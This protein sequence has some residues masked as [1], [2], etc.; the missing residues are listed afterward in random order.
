MATAT[1]EAIQETIP[2]PITTAAEVEP[3]ELLLR[4]LA[5]FIDA[6]LV[7]EEDASDLVLRKVVGDLQHRPQPGQGDAIARHVAQW[8]RWAAEHASVDVIRAAYE[9]LLSGSVG[10]PWSEELSILW[11]SRLE[12]GGDVP[13]LPV[14][15]RTVRDLVDSYRDDAAGLLDAWLRY[16]PDGASDLAAVLSEE[17]R[18][19][20]PEKI[21]EVLRDVRDSLSAKERE[22]ML[23]QLVASHLRSDTANSVLEAAGI[24]EVRDEVVAEWLVRLYREATNYDD[25]DKIL[26]MW[27]LSDVRSAP[28]KRQLLREVFVPI[29]REGA[30]SYDLARRRLDLAA[31][32][33]HGM[34]AEIVSELIQAAP[35]ESRL[36]QMRDKM[37][38]V[39]L[40]EKKKSWWNR[41]GL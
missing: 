17:V 14:E 36:A 1:L 13:E 15:R 26:Q 4:R 9:A 16:G 39:G 40:A 5:R 3:R 8:A 7:S 18:T 24:A 35:D 28:A 6:G 32:P 20:P 27:R 34:R 25:R 30:T 31:D 21:L 12:G 37:V 19:D 22:A 41:L 29:A 11:W 10:S 23:E 33:P 38:D 2:S